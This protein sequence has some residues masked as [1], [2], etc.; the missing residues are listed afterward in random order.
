VCERSI[1]GS[2][3]QRYDTNHPDGDGIE[4]NATTGNEAVKGGHEQAIRGVAAA[5]A[6]C[7][8]RRRAAIRSARGEPRYSA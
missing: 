7:P 8:Q 3:G 1:D 2:Q 4:A 6:D 5:Y